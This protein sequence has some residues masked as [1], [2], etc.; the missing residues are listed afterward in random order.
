MLERSIRSVDG[1]L[2]TP[3]YEFE[4]AH[5]DST[6]SLVGTIHIGTSTYYEDIQAYAQDRQAAGSAVH[7]EL[8]NK[9]DDAALK[10][11]GPEVAD[12][13]IALRNFGDFF[14]AICDKLDLVHQTDGITYADS[15]ENHDANEL[16]LAQLLGAEAVR[17]LVQA[18]ESLTQLSD[19]RPDFTAKFLKAV[20]RTL[21]VMCLTQDMLPRSQAKRTLV[22]YRNTIALKAVARTLADD[23]D[24]DITMIWGAGH[25][26][27]LRKGLER[28]GYQARRVRWL[29]A[30]SLRGR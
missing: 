21:P 5:T 17:K 22:D 24:R 18:N 10:A 8:V 30:F 4:H 9:A 29:G 15:W 6:L 26:P 14:T 13:V 2:A 3:L 16:E 20:L 23:P 11:A 28:Q 27:G 19:S 25:V 7:Y 12:S 1:T